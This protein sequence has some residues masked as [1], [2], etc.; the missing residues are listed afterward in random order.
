MWLTLLSSEGVVRQPRRFEPT[1]QTQATSGARF[2]EREHRFWGVLGN[3]HKPE[4]N[5]PCMGGLPL[6]LCLRGLKSVR[7]GVGSDTSAHHTLSEIGHG[8]VSAMENLRRFGKDNG[9]AKNVACPKPHE[10][11]HATNGLKTNAIHR[12]EVQRQKFVEIP[13][14]TFA[15]SSRRKRRRSCKR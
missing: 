4:D 11:N 10:S 15:T 13:Q 7:P 5:T 6:C 12:S 1:P 2:L 9:W 8:W 3:N 14:C